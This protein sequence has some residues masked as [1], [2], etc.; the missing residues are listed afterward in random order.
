MTETPVID[1]WKDRKTG[2]VC[3]SCIY[4]SMKDPIEVEDKILL[5]RCRRHS[6]TLQG[7]PVMYPSDWCGDHKLDENKISDIEVAKEFQDNVPCHE[8]RVDGPCKSKYVGEKSRCL[9]CDRLKNKHLRSEE[10]NNGIK[11]SYV[12]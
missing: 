11:G 4:Y 2:M 10:E 8:Y 12:F 7:W 9:D 5:G 3:K 1:N 6:P